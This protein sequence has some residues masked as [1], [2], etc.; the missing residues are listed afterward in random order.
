LKLFTLRKGFE[1]GEV[2]IRKVHLYFEVE[3]R[4]PDFVK[5]LF[6]VQHY[7]A[8]VLLSF[9]RFQYALNMPVALLWCSMAASESKLV[10]GDQ[11]GIFQYWQHSAQKYSFA[12]FGED[13]HH[14]K[15][16]DWLQVYQA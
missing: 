14:D 16:L 1:E 4:V 13:F 3:T 5:R 11:T 6:D 2:G 8:A 12:Y 7:G 10:I 15:R 9:E